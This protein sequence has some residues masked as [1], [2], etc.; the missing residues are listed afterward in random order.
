MRDARCNDH[1]NYSFNWAQLNETRTRMIAV[2]LN[3]DDL[4]RRKHE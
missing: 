3:Y 1:V 4:L 2:F